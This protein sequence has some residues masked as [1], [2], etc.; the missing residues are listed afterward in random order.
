[1]PAHRRGGALVI[2]YPYLWHHEHRAGQEE[3]QKNRPCVIVL[4]VKREADGDRAPADRT[5]AVENAIV[6]RPMR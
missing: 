6:C 5:S 3:G 4:A 1:M 2:S